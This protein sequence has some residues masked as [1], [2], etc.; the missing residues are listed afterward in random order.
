MIV[1]QIPANQI[2][3]G[4]NTQIIQQQ[5]PQQMQPTKSRKK[6]SQ[7]K[8]PNAPKR[9]HSAFLLY[10]GDHRPVVKEKHPGARIGDIAKKLAAGWAALDPQLRAH[11]ENL[12]TKEKETYKKEKEIYIKNKQ[13]AALAQQQAQQQHEQQSRQHEQQQRQHQMQQQHNQM[14]QIH[15]QQGNIS[16]GNDHNQGHQ[17]IQTANGQHI[18]TQTQNNQLDGT[19]GSQQF[20]IIGSPNQHVIREVINQNGQVSKVIQFT[21]GG[22]PQTYTIINQVGNN[23]NNSNGNNQ[24]Q[25]QRIIRQ[26]NQ[27]NGNNQGHQIQHIQTPN[28][29]IQE[30]ITSNNGNQNYG[31]NNQGQTTQFINQN[32]QTV[33]I[34][35]GNERGIN[36]LGNN[37]RNHHNNQKQMQRINNP[38]NLHQPNGGVVKHKKVKQIKDPNAPKR[39]HS[40]FLLYCADHRQELRK[41]FPSARIG[42]IA[43][44]LGQGWAN[45]DA[46]TRMKYENM[47]NQQKQRYKEEKE[48]YKASFNQGMPNNRNPPP[49]QQRVQ[50]IQQSQSDQIQLHN[51]NNIRIVTSESSPLHNHNIKLEDPQN[52]NPNSNE[53]AQVEAMANIED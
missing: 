36:N 15:L 26:I 53:A 29:Q 2:Q 41:E 42:D 9:P 37:I 22:Q 30:I 21:Q 24:H 35:G 5:Q 13:A 17:I 19:S 40:A 33:Q 25:Q 8:D 20:Q 12:S 18:I 14:N 50:I 48:A 28:G 52:G 10:C 7:P 32:G 11:Y 46:E 1:H 45:V 31:N 38:H 6:Q 43:K 47:S 23:Q 4:S 27:G 3:S 49:T 51:G 16:P 34:I 44:R 39:P